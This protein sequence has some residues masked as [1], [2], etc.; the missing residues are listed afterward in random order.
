MNLLNRDTD[1]AVRALCHLA[2]QPEETLSVAQLSPVLNVPHP[3]LRRILQTLARADLLHSFRGKGGGFKLRRSPDDIRL[4]ELIELFQGNLS[5][6]ECMAQG[7]PC[8]NHRHC[9]LRRTI[10]S[11]EGQ[12]LATMD[13]TT[14]A[15]LLRD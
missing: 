12:A 6:T 10:K 14:I 13:S 9:K 7:V 4:T 5:L 8:R 2:G 3:Y 11:I 15:S 1:Y